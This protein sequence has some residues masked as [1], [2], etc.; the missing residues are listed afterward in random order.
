MPSTVFCSGN[1]LINR[2]WL[3]F[4][5]GDKWHNEKNTMEKMISKWSALSVGMPDDKGASQNRAT[6]K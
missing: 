5:K 6:G 2:I 4:P 1:I 3:Q